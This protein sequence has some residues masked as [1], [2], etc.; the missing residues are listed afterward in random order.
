MR[1]SRHLA[2]YSAWDHPAF[3][4]KSD[5]ASRR[6]SELLFFFL[7]NAISFG[8]QKAQRPR[9]WQTAMS[10]LAE[11][12]TDCPPTESTSRFPALFSA[13]QRNKSSVSSNLNRQK[14]AISSRSPGVLSRCS[15][16]HA[17][18]KSR[19]SSSWRWLQK[20]KP[21]P[22]GTKLR[23][24]RCLGTKWAG[25]GDRGGYSR[26]LTISNFPAS[27]ASVSNPYGH[28]KAA[29]A[30]G[31]RARSFSQFSTVVSVTPQI[32]ATRA[33]DS[34]NRCLSDLICFASC[35]SANAL[36]SFTIS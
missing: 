9:S 5:I 8:S 35:L 25:D 20:T 19:N 30:S 27:S 17:F 26:S 13:R 14:P 7:L 34:P 23:R 31:I 1:A 18:P 4:D 15:T 16:T 36:A 21:L 11:V 22:S 33:L 10:F 3:F 12:S 32:S 2:A 24:R 29:A 6:I 28:K